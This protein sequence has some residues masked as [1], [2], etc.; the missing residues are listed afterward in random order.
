[1]SD[2]K[3]ELDPNTAAGMRVRDRRIEKGLSQEEL[4][5]LLGMRQEAVSSLE[6]LGPRRITTAIEVAA[7]LDMSPSYLCFGAHDVES[8]IE[9]MP[10]LADR[11]RAELDRIEQEGKNDE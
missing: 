9:A 1:M 10:E 11:I 8:L 7:A 6:R 4:G 5:D 2:P 3:E